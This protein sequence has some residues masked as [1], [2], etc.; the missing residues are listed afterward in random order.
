MQVQSA[1]GL[2]S[3][4]YCFYSEIQEISATN[5][6]FSQNNDPFPSHLLNFCSLKLFCH[7]HQT[8]RNIFCLKKKKIAAGVFS[9]NVI[10]IIDFTDETTVQRGVPVL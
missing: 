8:K 1:Y 9:D 3:L 4:E 7:G 10:P 6:H 5:Q 2:L